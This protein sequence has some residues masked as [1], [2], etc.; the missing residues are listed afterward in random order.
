MRKMLGKINEGC[1][2]CLL[3]IQQNIINNQSN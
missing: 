1:M 3:T 2:N